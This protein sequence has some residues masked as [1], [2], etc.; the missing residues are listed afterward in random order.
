MHQW[1]WVA[2]SAIRMVTEW[3]IRTLSRSTSSENGWT[4]EENVYG[5]EVPKVAATSTTCNEIMILG[6]GANKDRC[7]SKRTFFTEE[8]TT[9]VEINSTGTIVSRRNWWTFPEQSLQD[10]EHFKTF[11]TKSLRKYWRF[12][13]GTWKAQAAMP[14]RGHATAVPWPGGG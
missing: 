5:D 12:L 3:Y 6:W 1:T 2:L 9:W 11:A 8:V 13:E 10:T 7:R 4:G 14:F